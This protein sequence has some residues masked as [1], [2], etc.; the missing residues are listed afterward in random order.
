MRPPE[1]RL[2]DALYPLC[3]AFV[4]HIH[5]RTPQDMPATAADIPEELFDVILSFVEVHSIIAPRIYVPVGKRGLGQ[6]ALVCRRWGRICQTKIFTFTIL[7]SRQDFYDLCAFMARPGSVIPSAIRFLELQI[8]EQS[9]P[10]IHLVCLRIPPRMRN[11]GFVITLRIGKS[12][13]NH[14]L[15]GRTI[16]E[17]T[18]WR[19]PTFSLS[20]GQLNLTRVRF[21]SLEDL[22]R[23]VGE[24]PS[25]YALTCDAVTWVA[26]GR[27]DDQL[28]LPSSVVL[29]S[30]GV[31]Y[32]MVNCTDDCAVITLSVQVA[33]MRH[34][35]HH[36]DAGIM[37]AVSRIFVP[38]D[39]AWGFRAYSLI[40][41]AGNTG[42]EQTV[43]MFIC[44]FS[45]R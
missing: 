4:S 5:H 28:Y 42:G 17:M 2:G 3:S 23:V 11:P 44:S 41:Y 14:Q 15:L 37:R 22:A 36:E 30:K 45:L 18:P 40:Q 29:R 33:P 9:V 24:M 38:K 26:P 12:E 20:I 7:R 31:N 1:R 21:R 27:T 34:R 13:G 43:S 16:H 35:V 8:K 6:F 10:W 32:A 19:L 25:L 39:T